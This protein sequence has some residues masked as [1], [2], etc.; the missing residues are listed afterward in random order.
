MLSELSSEG[1]EVL[2][3]INARPLLPT[4]DK[5]LLKLSF[6][7]R[8]APGMVNFYCRLDCRAFMSR[9]SGCVYRTFAERIH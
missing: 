6:S 3:G 8:R 4:G 1:F 2:W 5:E 7:I 9:T